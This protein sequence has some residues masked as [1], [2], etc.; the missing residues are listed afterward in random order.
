MPPRFRPCPDCGYAVEADAAHCP[1]CGLLFGPGPSLLGKLF[2]KKRPTHH[3]DNFRALEGKLRGEIER[4]E[5]QLEHLRGTKRPLEERLEAA[6]RQGRNPA[7]LLE[8]LSGLEDAIVEAHGL[9]LRQR[10][11]LAG[12]SVQRDHNDIRAFM[13]G[14]EQDADSHG[15]AAL[16]QDR[17]DTRL[18]PAIELSGS[19]LA[20]ELSPCGRWLAGL[21]GADLV[22]GR[23]TQQLLFW[24][25][26]AEP[27][28]VRR[29]DLPAAGADTLVYSPSG[30]LLAVGCSGGLQLLGC[31]TARWIGQA[32]LPGNARV[33]ALCFGPSDDWLVVGTDRG[34]LLR[35]GCE[36][37]T[38]HA[39]LKGERPV[40]A[41]RGFPV[42][43]L[44]VLPD[45]SKLFSIAGGAARLWWVRGRQLMGFSSRDL[46]SPGLLAM[47]PGGRHLAVAERGFVAVYD[48]ALAKQVGRFRIPS[49]ALALR[50]NG[51]G[52]RVA[53]HVA[54]RVLLGSPDSRRV[55]E[56]P[57]GERPFEA[58]AFSK[59]ALRAVLAVSPQPGHLEPCVVD[60]GTGGLVGF[61]RR[62][63]VGLEWSVVEARR[64]RAEF[65]L[66]RV[67]SYKHERNWA[68][69]GQIE[70]M[71]R[72]AGLA[73]V[74]AVT[75]RAQAAEEV[76]RAGRELDL[77]ERQLG[78][79]F[80][81]L[82][83]LHAQLGRAVAVAPEL[84]PYLDKLRVLPVA[85]SRGQVDALMQA[86][87][88]TLRGSAGASED[89]QRQALT[90]LER[91][92]AHV[93]ALERLAN[94]LSGPFWGNPERPLLVDGLRKLARDFPGWVDTMLA[95]IASSAI[96]R[97]DTV[98]ESF[99]LDKLREQRA[100]IAGQT[101]S[102]GDVAAEADML[103]EDALGHGL[104]GKDATEAE[105][106]A[107]ERALDEEARRLDAET[108]A[109]LETQQVAKDRTL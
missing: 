84:E 23:T 90:Q 45:G 8:A 30:A 109:F 79:L 72:D 92:Q 104:M 60:Y 102:G 40:Q 61:T 99:G 74:Y 93:G 94:D 13:D 97:I 58:V 98:E 44:A 1:E 70:G 24:D 64:L 89:Q 78:E 10:T 50:Y 48:T 35:F 12:I 56:L 107:N 100:R 82:E 101:H 5:A 77:V 16:L 73:A 18:L 88:S 81:E 31:A 80:A 20:F 71:V 51:D 46:D 34:D 33:S 6:R 76:T 3:P 7:P 59:D 2:R 42:R 96:G 27:A 55:L 37:D 36:H 54:G 86:I 87:E 63:V 49:P 108:R 62:A 43:G 17:P 39:K 95:S 29:L 105:R 22:S 83:D 85:V 15:A 38:E 67:A 21:T 68:L 75:R 26:Q 47:E 103:L 91:F 41:V 19:L 9:I 4:L 65:E 25:L 14:V 28:A 52:E 32:A 53:V 106:Q 66:D 69:K 57:T 11:V